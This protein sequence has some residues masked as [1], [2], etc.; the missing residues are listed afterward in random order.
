MNCVTLTRSSVTATSASRFPRVP[1]RSSRLSRTCRP[2]PNPP[3]PTW[4]APA[5]RRSPTP[6][7]RRWRRWSPAASSPDRRCGSAARTSPPSRPRLSSA[8]RQAPSLTGVRARWG[9]RPSSTRWCPPSIRWLAASRPTPRS[10]RTARSRRRPSIAP[11]PTPPRP[12]SPPATSSRSAAAP[13]GCRTGRSASR[14]PAP[15]RSCGPSRPGAM[16]PQASAAPAR[17]S[18]NPSEAAAAQFGAGGGGPVGNPTPSLFGCA[19]TSAVLAS[20]TPWRYR[21]LLLRFIP[22]ALPSIRG[23]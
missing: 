4:R 10:L 20:G 1:A 5:R 9:T 18:S 8:R 14:T 11:S 13:P 16:H 17:R 7:R 12:W 21:A 15:P 6:T 22:S 23:W 19:S 2:S 3:P